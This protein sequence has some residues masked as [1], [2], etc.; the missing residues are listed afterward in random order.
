MPT[1]ERIFELSFEKFLKKNNIEHLNTYKD[2]PGIIHISVSIDPCD[3]CKS[4]R[5]MNRHEFFGINKDKYIKEFSFCS[6]CVD[7]MNYYYP[8]YVN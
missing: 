3:I 1:R 4:D 7:N 8:E 5:T 6:Y 2:V